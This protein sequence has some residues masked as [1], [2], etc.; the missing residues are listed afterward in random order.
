MGDGS[1]VDPSARV[2]V[3]DE[4][5]GTGA[6]ARRPDRLRPPARTFQIP[7]MRPCIAI[8]EEE[9]EGAGLRNL[10]QR[11]GALT[12]ALPLFG[13]LAMRPTATGGVH[14][15][16][17]LAE[18]MPWHHDALS[19]VDRQLRV[20]AWS[21]HSWLKLRPLVLVGEPGTGKS[22]L[23]LAIAAAAGARSATLNLGGADDVRLLA[24][25]ARGWSSCQPCWPALA[26]ANLETA[27]PLMICEEIDKIDQWRG[28]AVFDLLL[29]MLEPL[30][31]RA[32]F[33]QALLA[34]VD[35]SECSW[36]FTAN[37]ATQLPSAFRSR[38]DIVDVRAPDVA[39]FD[40]LVD[41]LLDTLAARLGVA[42]GRLPPLPQ[43][44]LHVY[45][46]EYARRRDVRVLARRVADGIAALLPGP[47]LPH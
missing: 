10:R 43:R 19:I 28:A 42:R 29:A 20:A 13:G 9:N 40:L 30:T 2:F 18:R 23:A 14:L 25:T 46:R 15:V 11:F 8:A 41:N 1:G 16:E 34:D 4:I 5:F 3:D 12:R 24:G 35:L 26:M 6:R 47:G 39:H 37:D 44:A 33:D 32:Y 36:I 38:V 22:H 27:N 7:A 21:G 45:L 31:A 17:E